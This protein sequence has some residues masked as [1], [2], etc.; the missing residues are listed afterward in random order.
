MILMEFDKAGAEW[1]VVAYLCGDARMIDIIESGKSPHV[2]TG[3]FI[4]SVPHELII[5]EDKLLGK[6]TDPDYLDEKRRELLPELMELAELD[7]IWLPRSMTVRQCGKKSNHGLN[8]A[9][10]YKRAAMEWEIEEREAKI[11]VDGYNNHAYPGIP[12]WHES[13]RSEL[14]K[15]R[16]LFNLFG[17]KI[18]LMDEWGDELFNSAYSYKPQSTIGMTINRA[19]RYLEKDYSPV[20]Y[21]ADP[22]TQTHDSATIQ[23]PTDNWLDAAEFAIKFGLEYMSPEFE[24]NQRKFTIGTDL[25]VGVE[26]GDMKHE[27]KLTRNVKEVADAL[28]SAWK[29]LAV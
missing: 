29:Q 21:K 14:K 8:Y 15:D 9:M 19:I 3:Y 10:R 28:A 20:C 1:V 7:A 6:I 26:W 11:I 18:E 12:L 23:Y 16:T 17:H 4:T 5:K 13:I 27:I 22:L 24:V 25:K 2:E